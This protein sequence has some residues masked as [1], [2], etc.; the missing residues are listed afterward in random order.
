MYKYGNIIALTVTNGVSND[1]VCAGMI[2]FASGS[3]NHLGSGRVPLTRSKNPILTM[4][5]SSKVG[6]N[7]QINKEVTLFTKKYFEQTQ[8]TY[9]RPIYRSFKTQI[10]K[11][12]GL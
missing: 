12:S 11:I 8:K 4:I 5:Y 10:R 1:I 9:R 3:N 6:V 2:H 7:P